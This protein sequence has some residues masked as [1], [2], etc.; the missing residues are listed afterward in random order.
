[1]EDK[2]VHKMLR[3]SVISLKE[4]MEKV[5]KFIIRGEE[6]GQENCPIISLKDLHKSVPYVSFKMEV[7]FLLKELL[8]PGD[9]CSVQN[10][11][12]GRLFCSSIGER[13][14]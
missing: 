7:L 1:M 14:S 9:L 11:P 3:E 6:K 8:M 12:K 10:K 4:N 13:V 5:F 2:E